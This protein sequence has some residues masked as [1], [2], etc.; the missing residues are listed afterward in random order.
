MLPEA[1][2]TAHLLEQAGISMQVASFH[3]V[4]PLDEDYLAQVFRYFALVATVEEHS[5]VGGFGSAVAE[6]LCEQTGRRAAFCRFGTA[7]QFHHESG[8][9][10]HARKCFGLTA[11]Q[12]AERIRQR[13]V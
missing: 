11:E 10:E 12:I 6:W 9:Q 1:M 3:T 7:D 8:E 4:K 2:E 13:L 5:L